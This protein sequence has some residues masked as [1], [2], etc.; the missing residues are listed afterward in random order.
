MQPIRIID[1]GMGNLLSVQKALEALGFPAVITDKPEEVQAAPGVILPGV[2][3]FGDAM[4]A[5]KK[6]GMQEAIEEV[7][8]RGTPFL[9]ICL[10]MQLLFEQSEEGGLNPG[11]SLLKGQ[12]KRL[13]A[14]VKVPHMGWNQVSFCRPSP[15]FKGLPEGSFFYFVHSYHVVAGEPEMVVAET[16]YG[17][18][19]VAAVQMENIFGV[20]FHPEKSSTLGLKVLGNFGEMVYR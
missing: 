20:Q 17:G 15:L 11:L 5:L 1:Y 3:A 10:G 2:G 8:R 6:C 14:G 16:E 18:R 19:V 9:G 4:A 7:C 12:V 13:P